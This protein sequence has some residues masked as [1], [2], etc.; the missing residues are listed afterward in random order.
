MVGGNSLRMGSDKALLEVDGD[1]LVMRTVRLLQAHLN[2]ITLLGPTSRYL[3]L[4]VPILEDQYSV[5]GPLAAL[6]TGLKNSFADWNVFL[7]CDLPFVGEKFIEKLL[8]RVSR[9]KAQAVIPYA[10]TRHQVLCAA[11]HRSCLSIFEG[12]LDVEKPTIM[13]MLPLLQVEEIRSETRSED[14]A[15]E[16]TFWNINTPEDW[17]AAKSQF[18]TSL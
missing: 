13:K 11:Y 15:W 1:P 9:T 10:A 4:N 14:V 18:D 6:C 3:S 12:N 2:D 5:K 7:A 8:T 16:R 17:V